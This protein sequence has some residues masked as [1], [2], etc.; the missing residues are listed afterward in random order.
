LKEGRLKFKTLIASVAFIALC[1]AVAGAADL[2]VKAPSPPP[3]LFSWTGFYIG[4]NIGGA[5]SNNR[6][7]DTL[8]LTNFNNTSQG[9][10]IGGGQIGG[11]Y[12]IGQFVIGG[13]WDFDW[14]ANNN[15]GSGVLIPGVGNIVVT[16][17]NRWITTVAARFGWAFDNAL[18]Y[19]KAGGGWVG[20]NNFAVTN[21]TTG[22][23]VTCG[24]LGLTNC[25]NNTGGW[26]VGAGFEYAFTNNW[27]V[28]LEYDYLGLGNR[29]FFVPAGPLFVAGDTFTTNNRNVQMLKV[30]VN[31]L[32]NWGA[33]V[34]ARY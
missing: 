9:V 26:L 24:T 19:G 12:Q 4:A 7:T 11:N 18:F 25:S 22:V 3:P 6:W 29:T 28:K 34:T 10:F 14:A 21:T 2:A 1:T 16:N 8:F 30:G 23:S 31:Y 13:E 17:N 27:T 20:S 32:F 5:W 33:P 15:N